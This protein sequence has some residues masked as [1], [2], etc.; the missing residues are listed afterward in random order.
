MNTVIDVY[1]DNG[2]LL[3]EDKALWCLVEGQI[4]TASH[5]SR[6]DAALLP[7]DLFAVVLTDRRGKPVMRKFACADPASTHL[8]SVYFLATHRSLPLEA[9][10]V[11]ARN[12]DSARDL[13]GLPPWDLHKLAEPM[14]PGLASVEDPTAGPKVSP[15]GGEATPGGKSPL[16]K[17]VLQGKKPDEPKPQMEEGESARRANDVIEMLL[18]YAEGR[19]SKKDKAAPDRREPM[20]E[21]KEADLTGTEVMPIGAKAKEPKTVKKLAALGNT[22]PMH[23]VTLDQE[24]PVFEKRAS[25][26]AG[27]FPIDTLA[28]LQK[29]ESLF[30]PNKIHEI[31]VPMRAKIASAVRQREEE[32]GLPSSENVL[33]YSSDHYLPAEKLAGALAARER[34][35]EYMGKTANYSDMP[36]VRTYFPA[37]VYAEKLAAMDQKHGFAPFWN[38]G[39]IGDPWVDSLG[40]EKRATIV[41]SKGDVFVADKHLEWLAKHNKDLLCKVLDK[42]V[43]EEFAKSPLTV[44]NS[45]PDPLK[46]TIGRLAMDRNWPGGYK[47]E[48]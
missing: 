45:L 37:Q 35:A 4:K 22:A 27:P 2:M 34:L 33:V 5:L 48:S 13:Y 9:V 11:A 46:K 47:E 38:Q 29:A 17:L 18:Q 7:D 19:K 28:E 40:P 14:P 39:R 42:D 23:G 30:A 10:K 8:S 32:L 6:E 25:R 36:Y 44:F 43:A 15:T 16:Q 12:L 26:M 24:Y 21:T 41:Y 31:S 20:D 1:D 3:A